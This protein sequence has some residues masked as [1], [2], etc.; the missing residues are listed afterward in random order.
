MYFK[1]NYIAPYHS[2]LKTSSCPNRKIPFQL[3]TR[4]DMSHFK[5]KC[6][7]LNSHTLHEFS[8]D[9]AVLTDLLTFRF[10]ETI[11]SDF[12]ILASGASLVCRQGPHR[13]LADRH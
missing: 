12:G 4:V 10:P 3:Y 6:N 8:M 1:T 2:L 5:L 7:T 13:I 11:H 9:H